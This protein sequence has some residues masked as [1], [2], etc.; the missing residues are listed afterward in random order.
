[1]VEIGGRPILWHIMK[2]Y[3]SY[4]FNEFIICLGY[5]GYLV[6]EFFKNYLLHVSDLT[7]DMETGSC[8]IHE[9][10]GEPF[11][12]TLID[13]GEETQTGGRLKRVA[14]HIG[15]E[16]F[17]LTYGDGVADIDIAAQLQFHKSHGKMATV[18]AI[19]PPGRFGALHL[20]ENDQVTKMGEKLDTVSA[21]INGGFFV[22]EPGV[23]DL[24][25]GDLSEW[26]QDP[27]TSLAAMGE[28]LAYRHDG[29]WQA[30]DTLRDTNYL[31]ELWESGKAPWKLW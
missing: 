26:E 27:M 14:P 25:D 23:L 11:K 24:I 3:S 29:F 30:M 6:K 12:V 16:P 22:L 10:R 13:T 5:K 1:M 20:E 2:I 9:K 31:R 18:A 15:N 21:F 4:G 17:F 28:L 7:L 19:V 8:Q